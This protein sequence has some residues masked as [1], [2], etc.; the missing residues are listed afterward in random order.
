MVFG[1]PSPTAPWAWRWEGHHLTITFT[2]LGNRIIAHTP[3]AFSSEPNTV[4]SGPYRGLVVLP[5]NESLGRALFADLAGSRQRKARLRDQSF[6]NILTLAGR[7]GLV[8]TPAG[9]ALGDLNT[10]QGNIARRLIDLYTFEHLAKPLADQ[11]RQRIRG[12]DLASARFGWAGDPGRGSIYYRLHGE[13]FLIEFATL[14]EQP[15]HH[16]TIV[17]DLQRNLGDYAI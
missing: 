6:G 7:E 17:H 11:Q 13:T 15:L 9:I 12:Q 8:G 14:P 1:T 10:S 5:E 3:K 16:H 4:P 2:L